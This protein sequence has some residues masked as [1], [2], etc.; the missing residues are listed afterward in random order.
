M[1]ARVV[2]ALDACLVERVGREQDGGSQHED[3]RRARTAGRKRPAAV[4]EQRPQ[5]AHQDHERQGE[6]G[7]ACTIAIVTTPAVPTAVMTTS[8]EPRFLRVPR[9]RNDGR[10]RQHDKQ[11]GDHDVVERVGR[12]GGAHDPK[13]DREAPEADGRDGHDDG[14][15]ANGTQSPAAGRL[16]PVS[17]PLLLDRLR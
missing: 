12:L 3:E 1:L 11:R 10:R 14:Q 13:H 16:R 7:P 8:S 4:R 5:H 2:G 9:D 17:Q 6:E 15:D